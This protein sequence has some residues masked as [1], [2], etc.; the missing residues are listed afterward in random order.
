M[1]SGYVQSE[2]KLEGIEIFKPAPLDLESHAPV[3]NFN[4]PRCGAITAYSIEDGGLKCTHCGYIERPQSQIA[5]SEAQAFEF[6]VETMDRVALGWGEARK[7]LA[8]Q[9]CGAKITLPIDVI[10]TTCPFCG[11]NQVIQRE[12]PQDSLRPRFLKPF[13]IDLFNTYCKIGMI[14]VCLYIAIS[15]DTIF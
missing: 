1:A 6:T 15:S 11:S 12:A 8:C 4:C 14:V 3:V 10:S 5:I 9:N 2:S 13:S 7:E